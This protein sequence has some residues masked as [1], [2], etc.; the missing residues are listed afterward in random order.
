MIEITPA[1]YREP[2]WTDGLSVRVRNILDIHN[3][4][5]REEALAAYQ[6]GR[7]RWTM[8]GP[9]TPRNYGLKSEREVAKWLGMPDTGPKFKVCPHCGKT[10]A[11]G[12]NG[13]LTKS[14]PTP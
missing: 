9:R 13:T 1:S 11:L 7:L 8:N 2:H 14:T 6:D 3:I 10:L 12:K 4:N 5:S